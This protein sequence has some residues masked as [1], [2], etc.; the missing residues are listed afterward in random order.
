MKFIEN[1][2]LNKLK[3]LTPKSLMIVI[4][5]PRFWEY[6]LFFQVFIDELE[7]LTE[8]FW[9]YE[10]KLVIGPSESVSNKTILQW[11]PSRFN[12][13]INLNKSCEII[14][15]S[16]LIKAIGPRGIPG[17]PELICF[18]AKMLGNIFSEL[19]SWSLRI[20][21]AEVEEPFNSVAQDLACLSDNIILLIKKYPYESITKIE[22]L[23]KNEKPGIPQTIDLSLDVGKINI[24]EHLQ[25]LQV[26][27]NEYYKK[28]K[29]QNPQL[30][31]LETY[32]TDNDN[33]EN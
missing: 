30:D 24:E 4:E 31:D 5:K 3:N 19:L 32:D 16:T 23:L 17:N 14:I 9:E 29:L 13:F 33:L 26:A 11:L 28:I 20:K 12:E 15:N 27:A 21:R 10:Q 25:K 8:L 2:E 7:N 6:F 18:C 1:K 22:E